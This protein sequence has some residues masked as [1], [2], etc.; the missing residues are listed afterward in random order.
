VLN[1]AICILRE[2]Q[3]YELA[4]HL[5]YSST[6]NH[7]NVSITI[8]TSRTSIPP[9]VRLCFKH[10]LYKANASPAPTSAIIPPA[11][12]VAAT[13]VDL[14]ELADGDPDA[15]EA[16]VADAELSLAL[17]LALVLVAAAL[18]DA[19]AELAPLVIKL[20]IVIDAMLLMLDPSAAS[21]DASDFREDDTDEEMTPM[22]GV[23]AAALSDLGWSAFPQFVACW[24][25]A[26]ARSTLSGQE[27]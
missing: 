22:S 19:D 27:L 3:A 11:P 5:R 7:C 6:I 23:V 12:I 14:V 18:A 2:R 9:P 1:L 21:D 24:A 17:V 25:C 4:V 10:P 26:G 16:D 15:A 20:D 8:S 13:P